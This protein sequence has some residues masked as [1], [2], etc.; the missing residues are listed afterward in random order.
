MV[1]VFSCN[2][3]S[4]NVN[5]SSLQ[6]LEES[7]EKL[8]D[9]N[10]DLLYEFLF[11]NTANVNFKGKPG[12]WVDSTF[13]ENTRA[14]FVDYLRSNV[15]PRVGFAPILWDTT[16]HGWLIDGELM[17]KL[18]YQKNGQIPARQD[19]VDMVLLDVGLTVDNDIT[20]MVSGV[21]TNKSSSKSDRRRL[22]IRRNARKTPGENHYIEYVGPCHTC[23]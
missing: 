17:A 7:I 19:I 16:V 4:E 11:Q 5:F 10:Q 15:D 20:L 18:I 23:P 1:G 9:K 8:E 12:Q 13:V 3:D 21:D 6:T 14:K 2:P 22:H